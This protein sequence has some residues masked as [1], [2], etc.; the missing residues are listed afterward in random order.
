MNNWHA[1][2]YS[3]LPQREELG[4]YVI[5]LIFCI[6]SYINNIIKRC[7]DSLSNKQTTDTKKYSYVFPKKDKYLFTLGAFYPNPMR[8]QF[9]AQ[10]HFTLTLKM[11]YSC[12]HVHV[13]EHF[14]QSKSILFVIYNADIKDQTF[15]THICTLY[16]H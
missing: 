14:Y 10:M 1:L 3:F 15:L 5:V 13:Q 7:L 4:T 11:Q 2:S 9:L 12:K 6:Y 16:I 8:C